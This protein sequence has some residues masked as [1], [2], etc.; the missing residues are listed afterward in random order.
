M[1]SFYLW[2]GYISL[3]FCYI[4]LYFCLCLFLS[5]LLAF[6]LLFISFLSPLTHVPHSC[7]LFVLSIRFLYSDNVCFQQFPAG[8]PCMIAGVDGMCLQGVCVPIT[9]TTVATTFTTT[10]T[11]L[12]LS[13]VGVASGTQCYSGPCFTTGS[14]FVYRFPIPDPQSHIHTYIHTHAYTYTHIHTHFLYRQ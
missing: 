13:C 14:S 6:F 7:T 2:W 4:G 5:C 3:S 12:V 1:V 8:S 9:S 11:V 10:R